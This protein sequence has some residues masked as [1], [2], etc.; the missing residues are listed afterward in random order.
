MK[1]RFIQENCIEGNRTDLRQAN[2]VSKYRPDIIFFELPARKG[3][4]SLIFN[5]YSIVQ[6]PFKEV[7]RI[8]HDLKAAAKRF[9][10]ALSDVR[11]WENIER[12]WR[13]GRNVLLFNIDGQ[14]EMRQ[15]Y[16]QLTRKLTYDQQRKHLL[17]WVHCYLREIQMANYIR[18]ILKNYKG[19]TAPTVAVFLQ[20]IHWRHVKFL[21]K[22]P[23]QKE[24]WKYYFGRF[25]K[26]NP[27]NLG[28]EIKRKSDIHYKYW[29]EISPFSTL[30]N[31]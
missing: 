10:Y 3:N 20:S 16:F 6:K 22:D 4:P 27:E 31:H 30:K 25:P 29:R 24:I 17:F 21:L 14:D 1:P 12:L 9:P 19:K 18:S 8:K 15:D 26:I 11:T 7:E 2:V 23:S 28:L 13:D 5:R